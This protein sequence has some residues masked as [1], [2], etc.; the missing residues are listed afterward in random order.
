MHYMMPQK[1]KKIESSYTK[2][3]KPNRFSLP[4]AP[5][6]KLN[7]TRVQYLKNRIKSSFSKENTKATA[8]IVN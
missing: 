6:L 8:N 5:T 1:D 7:Q 2:S 3:E 4:A